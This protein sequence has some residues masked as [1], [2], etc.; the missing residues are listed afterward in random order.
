MR[1]VVASVLAVLWAVAR[2]APGELHD[3]CYVRAESSPV[4]GS[5]KSETGAAQSYVGFRRKTTR[6]FEVELSVVGQNAAVCS[7]NGVA[8]LRDSPEGEVLVIP[9]RPE[10]SVRGGRAVAP[11]LVYVQ[12]TPSAVEV[13]TTEASCQAQALCGGQ[14]QLQGQ[15]FAL[16]G[17]APPNA[18]GPCFAQPAP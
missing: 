14:V 11:C 2:A 7:V 13:T 6:L 16:G 5:A 18:K 10:I 9:V 8:K 1:L 3:G 17:N 12:I 4:T 15:R